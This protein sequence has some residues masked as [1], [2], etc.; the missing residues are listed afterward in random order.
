MSTIVVYHAVCDLESY[1]ST[2]VEHQNKVRIL[3]AAYFRR[4]WMDTVD[5]GVDLDNNNCGTASV[6][7]LVEIERRSRMTELFQEMRQLVWVRHKQRCI[8]VQVAHSV[9]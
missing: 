2:Y 9:V 3:V 7:E 8:V 5:D 4:I 1:R 6:I